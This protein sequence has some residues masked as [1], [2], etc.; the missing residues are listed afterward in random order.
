MKFEKSVFAGIMAIAATAALVSGCDGKGPAGKVSYRTAPITRTDIR[1]TVEATG[2]ITPR[3]TKSGI[4][5]GAQVNGKLIKLFVDYNSVVTNGQVV[6]LIDP[7]VYAAEYKSAVARLHV[8]EADVQVKECALK[9]ARAAFDLAEK[10]FGRKKALVEKK[11]APVAD[12]DTATETLQRTT[13]AVASAEASLASAK[14]SVESAKASVDQAEANLGYCTIRSPVNGIVI[15]RK[16]EEG[17]TVVSSMNAVP[18]LS[19]AEDLNTI[20]VSASIPE[21]DIGN[22]KVGQKV[23]F[24]A[25]AYRR[26]F[27]GFVKQIRRAATTENNVV[28]FPVIIEAE[29]PEEMLFPGMTATLSIETARADDVIAVAAAAMRFRPKE[30][31]LSRI[32]GEIPRGRKLWLMPQKEGDPL[33][34]FLFEEGVSDDS[35]TEILGDGVPALEGREAVVGYHTATTVKATGDNPF[36]PKPPKRGQNKGTAPEPKKQ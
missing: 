19:I 18:V 5:V 25:D 13:A 15:D 34:Y 4:P 6:A 12:L 35:F 32:A 36:M 17:E 29:N 30:E 24:T 31:D 9:T 20:W 14:A 28:T 2:T 8:A 21:A 1:R 3:N 27:E 33:E 23:T 22:V 16:V 10:T 11:M 26:R 7:L